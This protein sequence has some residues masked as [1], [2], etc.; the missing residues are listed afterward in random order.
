MENKKNNL[1]LNKLHL[2]GIPLTALFFAITFFKIQLNVFPKNLFI[3]LLAFA[4][5]VFLWFIVFSVYQL[6]KKQFETRNV[7]GRIILTTL[8]SFIGFC[9]IDSLAVS[10]NFFEYLCLHCDFSF[11]TRLSILF[12]MIW[13]VVASYESI[14]KYKEILETLEETDKLVEAQIASKIEIQK[15][16]IEPTFL[17]KNL[18]L[19]VD[20]EKLTNKESKK[21]YT[22]GLLSFYTK[23]IDYQL[24]TLI[25]LNKEISLIQLY[26][27]LCNKHLNDKIELVINIDNRAIESYNIV[28][29]SLLKLIDNY[30]SVIDGIEGYLKI[31]LKIGSE[32][33]IVVSFYYSKEIAPVFNQHSHRIEMVQDRINS[34]LER[35]IEVI[36]SPKSSSIIVPLVKR[37]DAILAEDDEG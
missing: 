6:L 29:L 35:K 14:F 27:L 22:K 4:Q 10:F 21:L 20:S 34:I 16:A 11:Y 12:I 17:L 19:L 25:Y 28:P 32:D 26:H 24:E 7:L 23:A 33:Y 1:Q 5:S 30:V 8:I 9:L 3:I 36:T 15:H 31:Q 13:L 2:V 37:L 18:Q